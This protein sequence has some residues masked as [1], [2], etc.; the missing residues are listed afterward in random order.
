MIILFKLTH[1]ERKFTRLIRPCCSQHTIGTCNEVFA[2]LSAVGPKIFRLKLVSHVSAVQA[3]ENSV[4]PV[5]ID[6]TNTQLWEMTK[7]VICVSGY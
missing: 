3:V 6:N 1:L 7:Y 5:I 4:T 2:D